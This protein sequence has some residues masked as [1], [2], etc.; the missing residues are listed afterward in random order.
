MVALPHPILHEL[1]GAQENFDALARL[2]G[3]LYAPGDLKATGAATT[4]GAEPAGWLLCDG[5]AVS[6]TTYTTLFAAL[7]TTWGAGDGST[8]FNLPDL[9]GRA[10][11]GA[12]TGTG[13]S[14]RTLGATLGAETVVLSTAELPAHAHGG[15]TGAAGAKGP[16][17]YGNGTN[18][19]YISGFAP[20]QWDTG[21]FIGNDNGSELV[22]AHPISSEGGGGAH[23]NMTPSAVVNFLIKT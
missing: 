17:V 12:G 1:H 8:T 4:V 10:P 9:R 19:G 14:A 6:R 5:R 18:P 20:H 11:I 2:L 23:N 3:L 7:G 15:S 13:L 16:E 22:H 21:G